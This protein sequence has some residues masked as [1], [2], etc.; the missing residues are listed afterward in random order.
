MEC[1]AS[2]SKLEFPFVCMPDSGDMQPDL[3]SESPLQENEEVRAPRHEYR[4]HCGS[5]RHGYDTH[6]GYE[7]V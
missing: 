3:Y 7:I 1:N 5:T 6:Y 4:T 2:F